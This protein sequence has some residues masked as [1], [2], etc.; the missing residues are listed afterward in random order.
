MSKG[1][2]TWGKIGAW[3][4]PGWNGVGDGDDQLLSFTASLHLTQRANPPRWL[5][6]ANFHFR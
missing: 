4:A 1:I 6:Q 3:G 5:R 2:E